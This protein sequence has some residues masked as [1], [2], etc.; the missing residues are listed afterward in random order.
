MSAAPRQTA[1][2]LM[3][4]FREVGLEPDKRRGQNFLIDLNLLEIL[5]KEADITDRD[6]VLEVGTG[7][8]SLT[9]L[10][11]ER[12][13]AVVTVE[14]DKHLQLLASEVLD[15]FDNVVLLPHDAL[16]NKNH[17]HPAVIQA[18]Q[19]KLNEAPERRFKLAA[20]L[21]YCIATPIISN[22]LS[23]PFVPVSMTVTIQKELGERIVAKPCTKDYSALSIWIQAQGVAQILRT[24]PPQVFWPRPKVDSVIVQII[25]DADKRASIPDLEFFHTF[26]RSMFFHRRKFLRSVLVAAMKGQLTKPQVDK[27]LESQDLGPTA[28]AEELDVEK[29]LSLCE[30]VRQSLTENSS[31]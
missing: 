7:L 12:A 2:F 5:A 4:R 23:T 16:K 15:G 17:L 25:P 24:L 1:S 20:N 10:M 27:V 22:L 18:V 26:V 13:A 30:A 19:A 9:A 28:R 8:G 3:Q 21:P 11:A 6:V 14:I 31:N 29:M